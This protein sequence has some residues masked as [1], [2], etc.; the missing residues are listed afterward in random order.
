MYFKNQT[1]KF[2]KRK[3][4]WVSRDLNPVRRLHHSNQGWPNQ[5]LFLTAN[6]KHFS[7]EKKER[8]NNNIEK[9]RE[10]KKEKRKESC[11]VVSARLPT[12]THSRM[13]SHYCVTRG[14][15]PAGFPPWAGPSLLRQPGHLRFLQDAHID[16]GL[17]ADTRSTWHPWEQGI[18]ASNHPST[19]ASK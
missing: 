14:L 3:Y 10:K 13:R 6:E 11:L 9:K 17:S 12:R 8:H 2:E 16:A 7:G 5:M 15:L 4:E 1:W 18:P 19:Q